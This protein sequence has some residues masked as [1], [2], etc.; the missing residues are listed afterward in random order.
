MA[1]HVDNK[2]VY[3]LEV[4]ENITC[5]H[6]SDDN[7]TSAEI[8]LFQLIN[9]SVKLRRTENIFVL[10]EMIEWRAETNQTI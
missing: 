5:H 9:A 2:T 4:E 6:P 8:S 10:R 3:S 7:N 1:E